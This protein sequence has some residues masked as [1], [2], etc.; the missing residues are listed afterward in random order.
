M[1]MVLRVLAGVLLIALIVALIEY[2]Q[3]AVEVDLLIGSSQVGVWQVMLISFL[4]GA[5]GTA[6]ALT[7]PLTRYRL[8]LRRGRK[9]IAELE[10][11]VHGLRTL[12]LGG[13]EAEPLAEARAE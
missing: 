6:L 10:Q 9:R 11:E 13:E 7:W 12:P 1:R 5:G 3:E 8:R 4:V 2:N